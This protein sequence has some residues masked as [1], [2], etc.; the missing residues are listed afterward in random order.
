MCGVWGFW[1]N[2]G[3]GATVDG[4]AFLKL[5]TLNETSRGG[6][7]WGLAWVKNRRIY[8]YRE[9]G[10]ISPHRLKTLVHGADIA[11]G[12]TRFATHGDKK[13]NINNHPH[14]CDGGWLVHNGVVSDY[15]RV[16]GNFHSE[17]SSECDTEILAMAFA[18]APSEEDHERLNHMLKVC[19]PGG[20]N[21]LVTLL[22]WRDRLIFAKQGNP[23][24]MMSDNVKGTNYLSSLP[25]DG[26]GAQVFLEDSSS[27]VVING[28]M[29]KKA[30]DTIYATRTGYAAPRYHDFPV[31]VGASARDVAYE[32]SDFKRYEFGNRFWSEIDGKWAFDSA[33]YKKALQDAAQKKRDLAAL[34]AKYQTQGQA[35]GGKKNKTAT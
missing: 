8:S 6:H 20:T 22:L 23:L 2:Q 19:Q 14:P 12:H 9:T 15:Y 7:A 21:P 35:K 1:A 13:D 34:P 5:G 11:I 17:A 33:G 27:Y 28:M 29:E 4:E 26:L 10:K 3:S 18:E 25:A 32:E 16:K 24:V 31:R 30:L